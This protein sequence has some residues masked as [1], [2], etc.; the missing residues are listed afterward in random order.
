MGLFVVAEDDDG[1]TLPELRCFGIH[2]I[3]H[4]SFAGHFFNAAARLLT[5]RRYSAAHKVPQAPHTLHRT[6]VAVAVRQ[7]LTDCPI[8]LRPYP[9]LYL[10]AP[11][12]GLLPC[13]S[14]GDPLQVAFHHRR[15]DQPAL[16]LELS[17]YGLRTPELF[18]GY[19]NDLTWDHR[20]LQADIF[21]RHLEPDWRRQYV[22]HQPRAHLQSPPPGR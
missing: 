2:A 3:R 5:C 4:S 1:L 9:A 14:P 18:V 15:D 16:I 21:I 8:L 20:R 12:D 6:Q 17:G 11:G 10:S 13:F 19:T 22:L 7:C